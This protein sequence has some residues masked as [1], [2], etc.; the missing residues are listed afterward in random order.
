VARRGDPVISREGETTVHH[1]PPLMFDPAATQ[2]WLHQPSASHAGL[3][4]AEA[5][6]VDEELTAR[7]DRDFLPTIRSVLAA[8]PDGLHRSDEI[9]HVEL[10]L[11]PDSAVRNQGALI[12]V[13][14]TNGVRL[15]TLHQ[16]TK[17]FADRDQHGVPAVLTALGHIAGQVCTLVTTYHAAN[18]APPDRDGEAARTADGGPGTE[19][20]A[21]T[22][23]REQVLDA[24]NAASDDILD[25]VDADDEGLRDGLNLMVNAA[26]AYL[27]GEATDLHGV[28]AANYSEDYPTVLGWIEAA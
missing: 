7:G 5:L 8:E 13:D 24:V 19:P 4:L 1:T 16:D 9:S 22:F 3:T 23:T 2:V 12:T 20:A 18:P 21:A 26:I 28:V 14:L 25:A 27:C 17:D 10:W 15:A 6:G 11:I